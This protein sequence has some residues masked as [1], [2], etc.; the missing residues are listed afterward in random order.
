MNR[1]IV[2]SLLLLSVF[3]IH[4]QVI[5]T[6]KTTDKESGEA[7]SHVMVTLKDKNGGSI[8]GYSQTA[9]DG[10]FTIK[11][12]P[13]IA[14]KTSIHFSLM[15]YK[16]EIRELSESTSQSF[17]V[18]MKMGEVE[19]K[20]V[21]IKSRKIW[22]R[23]DTLVYNVSSFATEQDRSIGDV[24]KKMPG[25]DV[26]KDGQIFYNGKSINKF[27]IE[28]RD[29]LEGRYGI[30]T[31]GV[32]QKEVGRVEVMENHQPIKALD[33]FTFS[34]Q[35]AVNLKMK[36]KSKAKW[37]ATIDGAAGTSFKPRKT[38]WEGKFFAMMIKSDW[39]NITTVKSNNVG[40]D[41]AVDIRDFSSSSMGDNRFFSTDISR[42]GDLEKERTMFNRSHLISTSSLLGLGK[43]SDLKVQFH[44]LNHHETAHSL[45]ATTYFLSD[46]TKLI[47][48]NEK[49]HAAQ[50]T[51]AAVMSFETNKKA[52]YLKNI[53]KTNL[54]GM[55]N[56][57]ITQG[58]FANNQF[59]E[60]PSWGINNSLQWVKRFGKKAVTL[61]ATN[62]FQSEPHLLTVEREEQKY[63]QRANLRTFYSHERTSF[64]WD[65]NN[66]VISLNAGI[67]AKYR[68][69]QSELLGVSHLPVFAVNSVNNGYFHT[70]IGPKLEL[71]CGKWKA[72]LAIPTSYYNYYFGKNEK[73]V[74][75]FLITPSLAIYWTY[76]GNL[77][78]F[79]NGRL[80]TKP[81]DLSNRFNGFVLK[82]YRTLQQGTHE[83][84]TGSRQTLS[85][86]FDYK[87]STEGIFGSFNVIRIWNKDP[88]RDRQQ[89]VNDFLVSASTK[90]ETKSNSWL[91]DA[92]F[93]ASIDFI[94]GM[95]GIDVQYF[96]SSTS[97]ISEKISIPYQTDMWNM[98]AN[99][100]GQLFSWM[101]WNYR[102]THSLY[103]L[104]I[105]NAG[106]NWLHG[107]LH[108][109]Q[110]NIVPIKKWVLQISGEYYKNEIAPQMYKDLLM[111]NAKTTFGINRRL[112]LSLQLRNL[113]NHQQ[114][115]YTIYNS[116]SRIRQE[117]DIR[118]REFLIG[119]S[120]R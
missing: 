22:E 8:L 108:T 48:E 119:F 80:G 65:I 61:T 23:G 5:L 11:T 18:P 40:E 101:N 46:G 51:L 1:F 34:D 57:R 64:G 99:A 84:A 27:Y 45:L 93:S 49:A 14:K 86:G 38:L 28:G 98:G 59:V 53:L 6:G 36:D 78:F 91:G 85:G 94:R 76:S 100:N 63:M 20:E 62:E 32:P 115:G 69:F 12:T 4:S 68:D 90:Q 77:T 81:Y 116:L 97:L 67:E 42:V 111:I 110:C 37:I 92:S 88:F 17:I 118:G 96:S 50:N 3:A 87:N 25:F 75:D 72:I 10:S 104:N 2:S 29:L 39:Q 113:L 95:A 13:E 9:T 43:E 33:G 15:G 52:S 107:W 58:T 106:K 73:S 120:W 74:N 66:L 35:A 60:A 47:E 102:L 114:Y 83:Y 19:L 70:Y 109:L 44:Y 112:E 54:K 7:L 82:N 117:H 41:Y 21:V 24:L 71:R 103:S 26:K 31:Q 105:N 55:N 79:T 56:D 30:A 89:F 16:E